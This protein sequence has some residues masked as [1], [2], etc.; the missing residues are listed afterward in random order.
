MFVFSIFMMTIYP[1]VIMPMF[2]K[3]EPLKDGELKT[4]IYA[5]AD[6][7]KYPLNKLFVMDG[8]FTY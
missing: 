5:L 1:V 4:S 2:N 8:M 7:I 3:Y 6:R